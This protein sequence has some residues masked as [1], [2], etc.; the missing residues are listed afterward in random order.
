M[1]LDEKILR[2]IRLIGD[3]DNEMAG[4]GLPLPAVFRAV[5]GELLDNGPAGEEQLFKVI[6]EAAFLKETR[7][8][9]VWADKGGWD[10]FADDI[11]HELHEAHL[12]TGGPD[13]EWHLVDGFRT[14]HRYEV[15]PRIRVSV[16]AARERETQNRKAAAKIGLSRL[17]VQVVKDGLMTDEVKEQF[18]KL[19]SLLEW[20]DKTA[21][22]EPQP[23][24]AVSY[25]RIR[26]KRSVTQHMNQD[27]FTSEY[28]LSNP[29]WHTVPLLIDAYNRSEYRNK[30]LP[31]LVASGSIDRRL[32]LL[33]ARG[34]VKQ[35]HV[36]TT[37][38]RAYQYQAVKFL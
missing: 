26:P 28:V 2:R 25:E 38:R 20:E 15:L 34:E 12:I 1:P 30:L 10:G 29:G 17:E 37:S 32:K 21:E 6:R 33:V 36:P 18:R 8:L 11:L 23:G 19:H 27:V 14:N 13:F 9:A 3:G 22:P 35:Q 16:I 7:I 24:P 31:D 4:G 5:L